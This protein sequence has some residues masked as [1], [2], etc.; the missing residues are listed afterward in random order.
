[1]V[2]RFV[3][4]GVMLAVAALLA[5]SCSR[6]SDD[7]ARRPAAV[8]HSVTATPAV[9][10]S[11]SG[12]PSA[13]STPTPT[14]TRD[15]LDVGDKTFKVGAKGKRVKALQLRLK[16]LHYDPG[17]VDARFGPTTLMAVWAFQKVNGIK[18]TGTIGHRTRAAF[19]DPRQPKVL[20][21]KGP[22]NRVE[23]NLT[24]QVLTVYHGDE[25]QLISHIS[26]GSG[27][28][29][30]DT[31]KDDA[32]GETGTA[33][34]VAVTPTGDYRAGRR[35]AGWRHSKLGYL[36]NPVYFNGG[37][38]VHGEPSVPVYPASHGCVRIPMHTST[39]FPRIVKTGER[40]YVRHP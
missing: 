26:S 11:P 37:I 19:D 23:I 6:V 40:I 16:K 1:M 13:S 3:V 32:T 20:K 12:T 7:G 27:L 17:P 28:H 10:A 30:C 36:Y 14:R 34:G 24:K 8:T 25:I 22:G 9:S 21:P 2:R 31:Y 15:P 33:C 5:T 38:A 4:P 39:I 29:Y 18:P 35:I